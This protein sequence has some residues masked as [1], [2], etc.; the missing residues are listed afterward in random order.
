MN[1]IIEIQNI[2]ISSN[3][4]TIPFMI[5]YYNDNLFILDYESYSK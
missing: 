5:F 4:Y 2:E 1:I 3:E